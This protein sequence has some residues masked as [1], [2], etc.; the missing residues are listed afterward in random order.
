MRDGSIDYSELELLDDYTII[1][2]TEVSTNTFVIFIENPIDASL[3][4][5]FRVRGVKIV[6][7]R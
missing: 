5:H 1:F 7:R 3:K 2:K 4:A 6:L